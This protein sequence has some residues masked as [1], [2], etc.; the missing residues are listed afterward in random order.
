MQQG[1]TPTET[2]VPEKALASPR[3]HPDLLY[4][5][6]KLNILSNFSLSGCS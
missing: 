3:P 1:N 2:L 4:K 5:P 6:F